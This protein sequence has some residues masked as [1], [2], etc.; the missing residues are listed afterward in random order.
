MCNI[1]HRQVFQFLIFFLEYTTAFPATNHVFWIFLHKYFCVGRK[2]M[3]FAH[4]MFI[5]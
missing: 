5:F 3:F 4:I 2:K 1:L